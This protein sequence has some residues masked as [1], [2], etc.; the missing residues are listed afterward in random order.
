MDKRSATRR[1]PPAPE[2][3]LVR[4]P[5]EEQAQMLGRLRQARCGCL[6]GLHV[7]LLRAPGHGPTDIATGL[8]CSRSSAYRT[9]GVRHHRG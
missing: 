2:T 3:T 5:K 6:L 4:I 7:L 8:F 9:V 1:K